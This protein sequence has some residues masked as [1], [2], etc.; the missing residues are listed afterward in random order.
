MS[1]LTPAPPANPLAKATTAYEDV[2][3]GVVP[4]GPNHYEVLVCRDDGDCTTHAVEYVAI[5]ATAIH[6]ENPLWVDGVDLDVGV[7]GTQAGETAWV[8]P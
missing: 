6:L 7:P 1:D 5:N 4:K 8:W 3:V 2:Q